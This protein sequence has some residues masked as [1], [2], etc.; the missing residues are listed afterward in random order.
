MAFLDDIDRL[1]GKPET[2]LSKATIGILQA[3]TITANEPGSI[4]QDF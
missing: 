2:K 1:D 4:I 3:Q